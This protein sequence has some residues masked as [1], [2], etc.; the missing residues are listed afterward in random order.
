[1]PDACRGTSP[2]R[3][4]LVGG[5]TGGH[6]FPALAVAHELGRLVSPLECRLAV[7]RRPREAEW[8]QET[9][10]PPP[11]R[12]FA[13][14]M[15]FGFRPLALAR[16]GLCLSLGAAQ[17]AAW[18]AHWR[19]A[20][21][22]AFGGYVSVPAAAAARIWRVAYAFHAADALPDRAAR[23]LARKA[24]L[25]TV[26]YPEAAEHF[27]GVRVEVT[28]QP[29]RPWL[30]GADRQEAA[31]QLGLDA[32]RPTLLVAG[33]S[34]GARSINMAAVSAAPMLMA[35]TELQVLHLAGFRDYQA[36]EEA[37]AAASVPA[38]RW[39]VLP[40]LSQMQWALAL[41]DLAVTRA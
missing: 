18:L 38:E 14:P 9:G 33:G 3:I 22:L 27:A 13:A 30:L 8:A 28:G 11:I 17:A 25:V 10:L 26:N 23:L 24:A 12:L 20:A 32:G 2:V 6:I 37:L 40:F 19:P 36:V 1:M 5:G 34:Q 21:M 16:A 41:A 29:V 31:V 15:P 39:K 35:S 7:G 4:A